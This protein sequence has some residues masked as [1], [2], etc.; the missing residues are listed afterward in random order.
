MKA[1][2]GWAK[3]PEGKVIF[4]EPSE[5]ELWLL[6]LGRGQGGPVS[7][8]QSLKETAMLAGAYPATMNADA[9]GKQAAV[10]VWNGKLVVRSS[11][12]MLQSGKDG[13]EKGVDCL[14]C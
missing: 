12:N 1:G 10:R 14:G 6:G 13:V 8:T 3:S 7:G 11:S 9:L 2:K 4:P 5:K